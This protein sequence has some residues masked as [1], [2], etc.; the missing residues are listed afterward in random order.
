MNDN[1]RIII[2][3]DHELFSSG[4]FSI[5]A[6]HPQYNVVATL[7]RGDQVL[8]AIEMHQPQILVLDIN[9]PGLTGLEAGK[10]V[11]RKWPHI[12]IVL[13]TMYNP[14]D[15]GLESVTTIAD[16]YVLKD[17][18]QAVLLSAL[19]AVWAGRRYTDP[20][21][22][23]PSHH[24]KDDFIRRLKLSSREKEILQL[25]IQGCTNKDIA[26]RLYLSEL[27]IKT[28]RKNIMS[29]MGVHNLAE[30]IKKTT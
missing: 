19:S 6:A 4:L 1:I 10:Q 27:T 25:I 18:G 22:D 16:A 13:V 20:S 12:K 2:A 28:H 7:S 3:D 23:Q 17:S 24:G 5:L 30:L 15:I 14:A 29:K 9:M 8:E 26:S 21:I 11:K